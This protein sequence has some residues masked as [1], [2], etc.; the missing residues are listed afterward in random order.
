M[1]PFCQEQSS[2]G[3]EDDKSNFDEEHVGI[4][5][6]FV[7]NWLARVVL[8][9]MV[10]AKIWQEMKEISFSSGQRWLG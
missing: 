2:E 5:A 9:L 8:Q 10:Q 7:A 6:A 3:R 1:N 4:Q